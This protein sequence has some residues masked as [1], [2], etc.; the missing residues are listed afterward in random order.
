LIR[1]AQEFKAKGLT[2]QEISEELKVQADTVVWLLLRG[3]ER[4][5]RPAPIDLFVDWSQIGS[6]VRRL[7]LAGWALADLARESIMKEEF[8]HPDVIVAVEGSGMVLGM[9]VAEQ[10]EKP[11]AAV[12]PQRV[13]DT[14]LSGA[15]NPSFA[16]IDNRKVLIVDAVMMEGETIRA[17]IQTVRSVRAKPTGI[18]VLVNKSNRDNVDGVALKSLIQL[19]TIAKA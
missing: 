10:L 8:E 5:R 17:T 2:T 16:Q 11:L 6:S 18:V 4:L 19:F 7:S 1:K 14:K 3:K 13:A 9:A 12:K 15:I